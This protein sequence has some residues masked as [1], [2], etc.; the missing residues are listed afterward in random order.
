MSVSLKKITTVSLI[1]LSI[2][3]SCS[4]NTVP[5]KAVSSKSNQVALQWNEITYKAFGGTSYQHSLMAARINAMVHL[6]M[7]DALNAIESK[8]SRYAFD[9]NDK[10]ADP[11][12]ALATAAHNVLANEIPERKSFID[13]AWEFTLS[14]VP[15]GIAKEKGIALGKL[16]A[17]ALLNK[18]AN[19]G[20]IGEVFG[21]VPPSNTPGVYQAVPPFNFVFAP[22]WENLKLFS[23]ESK[24]QFRPAPPP[25][26][27][28]E[29]YTKD[30]NEVKT[31]GMLNSSTRTA[32]QTSYAKFWYEFSEAG[33]NRV[34][35]IAASVK[36]LNLLETVRLFALVN[37]AIADAYTAGWDAKMHYNFWRPYTAIRNASMDNNEST[38]PDAKWEP[39]EP[40][41]PVQDYPSTHSA[42]G[43]A[44]ATVLARVLGDHFQFTMTSPT[45]TPAGSSRSF[46]SFSQ[47]ANENADSRV[48]AGIHFRFSCKAGQ[49]L[50]SKIGN[51]TVEQHL[52]P[53]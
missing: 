8:Y 17:E 10:E 23:L 44:G 12:A 51:W 42:L 26:L 41:P 35:R 14:T 27:N 30:F 4:K 19:D 40:T 15:D 6:A 36:D 28:S 22:H 2:F 20:N 33:W 38:S 32:N 7:H 34:A 5:Q 46:H 1:V 50:G 25:A 21:Q 48:Q 49:E 13:S 9:G 45:A 3:S 24:D 53:L 39:S 11:I 29:T 52:R 37:M 31:N 16:A 47:A 43:N 18:R